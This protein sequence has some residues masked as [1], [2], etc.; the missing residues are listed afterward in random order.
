MRT[1][2]VMYYGWLV[3]C[4]LVGAG[5]AVWETR[6]LRDGVQGTTLSAV[7]WR[8]RQRKPLAVAAW[9]SATWVGWHLLSPLDAR[10]GGWDDLVVVLV[11]LT[12]GLLTRYNP[13]TGE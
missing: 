5:F 10:T 1:F 6:A 3:F 4:I 2:E 13:R 9:V 7:W 8:L 12:V 11:G